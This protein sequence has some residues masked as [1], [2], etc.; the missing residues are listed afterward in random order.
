MKK[1]YLVIGCFCILAFAVLPAQAFTAKDLTVTIQQNGDAEF[2]LNYDLSW[3]EQVA[4]YFKIADPAGELKKG[5]ETELDRPVTVVSAKSSSADV[6]IPAFADATLKDGKTSLITPAFTFSRAQDAVNKYWFARLISPNF[7]PQ[8]T[9]INF[10]DGY[11][12]YYQN[13]ID[14]PSIAH[15][16]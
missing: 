5:V 1:I 10:P 15:Q 8:T 6:I 4:V 12:A 13:K 11:R 9:T 16:I 2:V 7:T 14:I 3:V